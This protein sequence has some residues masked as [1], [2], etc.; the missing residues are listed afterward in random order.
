MRYLCTVTSEISDLVLFLIL[1]VN[2]LSKYMRMCV[3]V[4]GL[5]QVAM[6]TQQNAVASAVPAVQA[7]TAITVPN[8]A[9]SGQ[10]VLVSSLCS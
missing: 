3:P 2:E 6:P 8:G 1:K 7:P 5:I 4:G 10:L 9:G